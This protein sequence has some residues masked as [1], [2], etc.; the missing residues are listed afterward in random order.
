MSIIDHGENDAVDFHHADVAALACAIRTQLAQRRAAPPP[1]TRSAHL[2]NA[3]PLLYA[4]LLALVRTVDAG[5][6]L[7]AALDQA[8]AALAKADGNP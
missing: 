5:Q 6:P 7:G 1:N 8:R 2:S 4:A 3:A